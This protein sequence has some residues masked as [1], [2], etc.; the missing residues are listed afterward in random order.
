MTDSKPAGRAAF[1]NRASLAALAAVVALYV[2]ARLWRLTDSCLWFDEIFGVHAAG[3]ET[4][5]AMLRFVAADAIHPPFFY[6][7][8][9][10]WTTLG[11]ESLAWLRLLPVVISVAGLVPFVLLARELGLGAGETN[12]ALLVLAANGY[13]IKYAQEVRMYAPLFALGV[14]SLWLFVRLLNARGRGGVRATLG[15]LS[16]VNLLLFY[17]HY[18]GWLV[19]AAQ[20]TSLL[21]TRERRGRLLA[22][23]AASVAALVACFL[24]WVYAVV[25]ATAV[26]PQG[27]RQN[28]GWIARP[29]L[30]DVASFVTLLSEPFYFRQSNV[31]PLHTRV[32]PALGLLL[33]VAPVALLLFRQLRRRRDAADSTAVEASDS[34]AVEASAPTLVE[35][36]ARPP[37]KRGEPWS[38]LLCFVLVPLLL[39]YALS[40]LLPLSVWGARHLVFVA[41]PFA[42]LAGAGLWRLRPKWLRQAALAAL[43]CWF[44]LVGAVVSTRRDGPFI[45][46]AWEELSARAAEGE[47]AGELKVYTFEDVVAYHLWFAGA[48]G[49]RFRVE[50]VKNVAGL[51]EDPAYFLPRAF[52][53][54]R[55]GAAEEIEGE[56]FLVAFRAAA[57]R[58]S[59]PPLKILL[60]RG[61]LVE[62]VY[63][64]SAQGQRAFLVR[65]RRAR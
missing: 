11:G 47:P 27:V 38:L 19:V 26:E 34:S 30:A 14:T 35:A 12:V 59:R 28:L 56:Q 21:F 42:L 64:A 20:L 52:D 63:E 5:G 29:T 1:F 4:W 24:P 10:V 60:E 46:C 3:H 25:R 43:V 55:V 51:S 57:W 65:V 54:V 9:K 13:L 62:Q 2:A 18:Y 39:A 15:A 53:S 33:F 48:R 40:H 23:Y 32:G 58:E 6:A 44:A 41:A 22:P 31:D 7:L 49:G 45:W 50:V 36:T 61:Y 37:V 17:T 8:L 16:L